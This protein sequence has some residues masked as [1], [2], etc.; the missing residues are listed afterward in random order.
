MCVCVCLP[1]QEPHPTELGGLRAG[2]QYQESQAVL[3]RPRGRG[4]AGQCFDILPSASAAERTPILEV[5]TYY[6]AAK[7][8]R[9]EAPPPGI[10]P[11]SSAWQAEILATILQRICASLFQAI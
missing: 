6:V 7:A 10:E 2:L 8:M 9:H 4:R 11:G 1:H 5:N 3:G